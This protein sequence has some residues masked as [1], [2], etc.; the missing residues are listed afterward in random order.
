MRILLDVSHLVSGDMVDIIWE[1]RLTENWVNAS[2]DLLKLPFSMEEYFVK[3]AVHIGPETVTTVS[4]L[5]N[6]LAVPGV[7]ETR[8][9]QDIL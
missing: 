9:I 7:D 2:D 6:A 3:Q 1:P 5:Q 4:Q 8:A